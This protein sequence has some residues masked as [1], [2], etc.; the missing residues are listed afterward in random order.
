MFY[1]GLGDMWRWKMNVAR[2][3][4]NTLDAKYIPELVKAFKENKDTRIKCMTA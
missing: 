3:M 2:A 4:G 1:M